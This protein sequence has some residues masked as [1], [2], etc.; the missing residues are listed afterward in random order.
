[1]G[2]SMYTKKKGSKLF[3]FLYYFLAIFNRETAVIDTIIFYSYIHFG[4]TY[5][6]F[7]AFARCWVFA[8]SP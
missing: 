3:E 1:M 2:I 5:C 6:L 8:I 7:S 4:L